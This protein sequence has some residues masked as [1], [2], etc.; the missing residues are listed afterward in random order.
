MTGNTPPLTRY[1]I[2]RTGLCLD[3]G[4]TL[5]NYVSVVEKLHEMR[6]TNEVGRK[7]F[8][9]F[10]IIVIDCKNDNSPITLVEKPAI[11]LKTKS[12]GHLIRR[13]ADEFLARFPN[14]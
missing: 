6:M 13:I 11:D 10:G 4:E 5:Q 7:G 8:D 14:G 2:S 9:A 1:T 12:Y 3:R